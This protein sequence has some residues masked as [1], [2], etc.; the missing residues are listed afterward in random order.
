MEEDQQKHL[1]EAINVV[2]HEAAQIQRALDASNLREALKHSST[3][4]CELR[5]SLL[6]P[7]NYYEL[8][9]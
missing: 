4:I 8:Y 6:S 3:M 2:K 7:R 5:T 9:M 1:D